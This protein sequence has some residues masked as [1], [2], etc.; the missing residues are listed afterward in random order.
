MKKIISCIFILSVTICSITNLRFNI[1]QENDFSDT[2]TLKN[3]EAL[4]YPLDE[5]GVYQGQC[6]A[7]WDE[8]CGY[9][10]DPIP[11]RLQSIVVINCG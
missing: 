5:N 6:C 7:P 9:S 4:A 3:L 10:G 8:T 11:G 1:Q 2:F